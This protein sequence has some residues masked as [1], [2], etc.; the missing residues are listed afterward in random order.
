MHTDIEG[1]PAHMTENREQSYSYKKKNNAKIYVCKC[2]EKFY[3]CAH[4]IN[5]ATSR[6][7][8]GNYMCGVYV[9]NNDGN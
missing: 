1:S 9:N 5:G 2:T 4:L 8:S 6:K 7:G 3:N